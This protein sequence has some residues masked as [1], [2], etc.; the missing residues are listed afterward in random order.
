MVVSEGG[1][2]AYL[3]T[4]NALDVEKA[5]ERGDEKARMIQDALG[6]QVAKFIGEMAVVLNGNIDGILLTGGV[7][8]NQY[9]VKYISEKVSFMGPVYVYPGEDELEALAM[10]ALR[11]ARGET[12]A[13]IYYGNSKKRD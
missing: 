12:E 11:V 10:N 7:A 2:V 13:K 3:G 1:Y 4:N 5:A 9:L 8:Y 6:Y